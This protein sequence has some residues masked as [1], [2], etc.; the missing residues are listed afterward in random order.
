MTNH[1]VD[2]GV[3]AARGEPPA[4]RVGC[5]AHG[6]ETGWK[7]TPR[8]GRGRRGSRPG[9]DT[10]LQ[11]HRLG[12]LRPPAGDP[13]LPAQSR[14]PEA[15]TRR[16]LQR[17]E[18]HVHARPC[19]AGPHRPPVC[20]LHTHSGRRL[21]LARQQARHACPAAEPP[22]AGGPGPR[23]PTAARGRA[24]RPPRW[25]ERREVTDA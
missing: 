23:H 8:E 19:P 6:E 11:G 16:G 17:P 15:R 12:A 10:Q 2:P 13:R 25:S 18:P 9:P 7:I 4:G 20:C 24:L 21:H 3:E 5:A 14:F 22:S 1:R